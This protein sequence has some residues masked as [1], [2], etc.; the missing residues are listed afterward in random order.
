MTVISSMTGF[1]SARGSADWG[2]WSVEAR[3]VNGRGL[4]VRVSCPQGFE[5]LDRHAKAAAAQQFKRGNLQIAIRIEGAGANDQL[6]INRPALQSLVDEAI[7]Q[8]DD[9]ALSGQA[10]ATL[11]TVRGIVDTQT[12]DLSALADNKNTLDAITAAIDTAIAQLSD[13]RATEGRA[14]T[15]VF[16]DLV[17]EFRKATLMASSAAIAQPGLLKTR[18]E[19]QL[20]ELGAS[21]QIDGDRLAAEIA[22]TVAKADVREE[23]DRLSAHLDQAE[24]L[25][26][27]G[28]PCGRKLDFLSQ[29]LGREINTLCS[30]S[31]SLDLTNVGLALKA[32]ND[33]FKEQAANVE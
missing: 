28:S 22:M 3:S 11:L 19:G 13:M 4:D 6:T 27:A 10:L 12:S 7:A 2:N 30:K 14:L 21:D 23:L 17:S 9:V 26:A 15:G 24:S 29:E 20:A 33:Q 32:L 5:T 18:L 16:A 1:G 8:S 31:A 25:L